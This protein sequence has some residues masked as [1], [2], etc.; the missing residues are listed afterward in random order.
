[1]C[2]RDSLVARR[3]SLL[4]PVYYALLSSIL[5]SKV[6]S[7]DETPIKAGRAAKAKMHQGC[8]WALYGDRDEVAFPY[9]STRA[10]AT[11]KEILGAFCGTLLTDGYEACERYAEREAAVV[12]AQ[13]WAHARRSFIDAESVEPAAC[14]TALNPIGERYQNEEQIR[15]QRL[16][17]EEKVLFRTERSKP[18]VER[19]FA[20][21]AGRLTADALLPTSPFSK[22]APCALERQKGLSDPHVHIDTNHLERALRVS[23]MGRRN[24]LFC[25][26]ELGAEV[27][28][29]IQLLL[30]TCRLHGVDPYT[31]LVDVLQRIDSHPAIDLDLLTPRIWKEHFAAEPMRSDVERAV[32]VK[33][34]AG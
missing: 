22:A 8:F 20:S 26:T 24:W 31:Y 19:F 28:G 23:P 1:M 11:A 21:L 13:C 32:G 30:V 33:G 4:E 12:L 9:S 3:V 2:I 34:G 18:V 14:R 29:K 7:M 17:G 15:L 10:H 25:W 27:V 16:E 5:G 6:L